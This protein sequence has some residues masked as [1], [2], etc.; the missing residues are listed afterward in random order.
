MK[1]KQ[2]VQ[3]L[4]SS[5]AELL[6]AGRER[7]Q[8][9]L[10]AVVAAIE[11]AWL[12][13][14]A[15][16]SWRSRALH[17]ERSLQDLSMQYHL[18]RQRRK[19]LHNQLV[20]LN[21]SIRVHCRIRPV[22]PFDDESD[23]AVPRDSSVC[24]DVARA[25]DDETVL[26]Q[27]SRPGHPS[28]NKTFNFER[29]YGPAEPQTAVFADVCPLL[30][31]L[32]D[33]YDVCVLALGQTGSGKTYTM[34]G[35]PSDAPH[36]VGLVPRAV[37]GLFRLISENP[38]RSTQ[39]EVSV[40]EVYNNDIFDLLAKDGRTAVP[41]VKPEVST[42]R[43]GRKEVSPLTRA[44][45]CSA[46]ECT[47]L[48][49]AGLQLRAQHATAV[50]AASS[51]SHLI[52]TVTVTTAPSCH[53][54]AEQP[55]SPTAPQE[56]GPPQPAAGRRRGASRRASPGSPGASPA[57]PAAHAE[58]VHAKLQLVD[59]A[60]SECAG[61]SGVTGSALRETSCINRSLAA[62]ADVLRALWERRGHVPYRNSKLTHVLQDALGGDAKL[63]VMVCVSPCLKHV[64]ETLQSL[65]FGAR[66]RQVQGA[67]PARRSPR[68]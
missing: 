49:R 35:P 60:G 18:E 58:Q 14:E 67:G 9:C 37:E 55:W 27:C 26:V 19:L 6:R 15:L 62:L 16:P 45:V 48:I 36:D 21:G 54:S 33:G 31:S 53:S 7:H 5:S 61:V 57:G 44:A 4:R 65:G 13:P 39:V 29:V 25:V 24:P 47:A 66:A 56:A 2:D 68:C 22:L 51:R 40:M 50:H 42:T 46:G 3:E 1:L 11:R 8:D 10:S 64:A 20:E 28:I 59:L 38:S 41:G 43:E 52:V 23:G 12:Q 32:L 63:L 34:L 17:L 30:T